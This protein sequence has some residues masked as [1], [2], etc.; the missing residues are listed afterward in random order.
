MFDYTEKSKTLCGFDYKVK[1]RTLFITLN[2]T[3][4][5]KKPLPKDENGYVTVEFEF[6]GQIEKVVYTDGKKDTEM[7]FEK[8]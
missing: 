7:F 8:R 6:E 3:A 1:G 5:T 4:G 2:S